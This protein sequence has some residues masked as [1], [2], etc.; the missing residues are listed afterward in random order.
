MDSQ[1][2]LTKRLSAIFETAVDGIVVI[3]SK[4]IIED[5][6][7]SA[8]YLFAYEKQELLG[9]SV[10][11]LMPRE[12][13]ERHDTY[14][15]NYTSTRVPK[16]IG[17]GREVQGLK[18]TGQIFPFW[19]SVSEVILEERT[20]FTGFIHD[21]SRIKE[22]EEDLKSLNDELEH[23]VTQRTYE[24]EKVVNQLLNL[25]KQLEEEI[26]VRIF[27]EEQLKQREGEL[28]VSLE[29]E[30]ELGELKSRFV[31]MASHEF[32]TPLSTIL[33]SASLISKYPNTDQQENREKHILKIKSSVAHLTNILN[34]FLSISRLEEGKQ[35]VRMEKFPIREFILEISDEIETLLKNN[36]QFKLNMAE[37]DQVMES[38]PVMLKNVLLNLI[39][40]AIKYGKYDTLIELSVYPVDRFIQF[41]VK[42]DG[43]GIP[44]EDQ[45]YLFDRFFRAA[46]AMNIEGT[47]LGLHIVKKYTDLLNG[48]LEFK[49]KLSEGTLFSI[50]LPMYQN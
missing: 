23:K 44:E 47:G 8:A 16:I 18:K 14:I 19:L 3:N 43:I 11:V 32:R 48:T 46:N 38:D 33:S 10:N 35:S 31:S 21:L 27:T 20:I 7:V 12:H 1:I 49:S 26:K 17:I 30:K 28:E 37:L 39:S 15:S 5:L 24:L 13:S 25:N 40:N 22:V 50:R 6:N 45:K 4:G 9:K 36:Q 29:K 42:D 2:D 41:E 34:D